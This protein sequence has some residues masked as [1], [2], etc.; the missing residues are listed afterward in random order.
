M[1]MIGIPYR[2]SHTAHLSSP[3]ATATARSRTC[4]WLSGWVVGWQKSEEE[5]MWNTPKFGAL[6]VD[7][8]AASTPTDLVRQAVHLAS[9]VVQEGEDPLCE[10]G[11]RKPDGERGGGGVGRQS[12]SSFH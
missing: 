4:C 3:W 5:E 7:R 2:S 6:L 10:K 12:C 11:K 9:M 8:R 1:Q